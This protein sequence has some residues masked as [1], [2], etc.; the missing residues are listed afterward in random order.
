MMGLNKI[1]KQANVKERRKL[2]ITENIIEMLD[3]DSPALEIDE[4]LKLVK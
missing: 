3:E 2:K 4:Y 1:K